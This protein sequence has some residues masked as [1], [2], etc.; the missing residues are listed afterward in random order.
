MVIFKD[1]F[2]L[3]DILEEIVG[4]ISD[5]HDIAHSPIIRNGDGS[6]L[7][8]G[9]MTIRDINRDLEWNLSD[10]EANTIAGLVIHEAQTIPTQGQLFKF[11]GYVY[12]IIKREGNKVTRIKVRPEIE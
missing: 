10:Q 1:F 4:E 9:D 3:E 11:D 5:E 2:L 6:V 7:V 8:N 12:E